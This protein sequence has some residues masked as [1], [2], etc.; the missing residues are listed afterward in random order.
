[1]VMTQDET[2]PAP[3]RLR[4]IALN[5]LKALG[6]PAWISQ[7]VAHGRMVIKPERFKPYSGVKLE[8]EQNFVV[9][10]HA[11]LAFPPPSSLTHLGGIRFYEEESAQALMLSI[12]RRWAGLIAGTEKALVH[13]RGYHPL[14]RLDIESWMIEVETRDQFGTVVFRFDGRLT[15]LYV[16]SVDGKAMQYSDA[17]PPIA[18]QLPGEVLG[19]DERSLEPYQREARARLG[20]SASMDTGR[21]SLDLSSSD[22]VNLQDGHVVAN[23]NLTAS[24]DLD[25]DLEKLKTG[26]LRVYSTGDLKAV[27]V[28]VDA[29]QLARKHP[30]EAISVAA[31]MTWDG[32]ELDVVFADVSAGGAF[33]RTS[34]K[35]VPRRGAQ[36]RFSGF[37]KVSVAGEVAFVRP[38]EEAHLFATGAG[39]GISFVIEP[40]LGGLRAHRDAPAVA[41]FLQDL[42]TRRAAV[43]AIDGA[44]CFVWTADSLLELA[45]ITL[46]VDIELVVIDSSIRERTARSLGLAERGIKVLEVDG[47]ETLDASRIKRALSTPA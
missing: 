46:H 3:E 22:I 39:L 11:F 21:I 9:Y 42:E 41:V 6:I 16:H 30:R 28:E 13:A 8:P 35:Q 4:A 25:L 29:G 37:G 18:I 7:G 10:Q 1:M 27:Q 31:K 24:V 14:A 12:E 17:S 45:V 43:T 36:V 32:G 19:F 2:A 33:A 5:R 15:I 47:S 40:S 38:S 44:R 20:H 26:D 23:P 34:S